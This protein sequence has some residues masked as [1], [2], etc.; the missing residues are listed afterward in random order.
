VKPLPVYAGIDVDFYGHP[1]T[2]SDRDPG[3]FTDLTS[4]TATRPVD[5]R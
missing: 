1:I 5:P 4:T 3:P 2:G